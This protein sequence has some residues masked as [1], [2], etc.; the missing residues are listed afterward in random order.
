MRSNTQVSK[1]TTFT[2]YLLW[3]RD[4]KK[5]V[6][7][8]TQYTFS[9]NGKRVKFL[10]NTQKSLPSLNFADEGVLSMQVYESFNI[11]RKTLYSSIQTSKKII[12]FH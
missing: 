10:Y 3:E 6:Y 9:E 8:E 12:F 2:I 4:S 7:G 1:N 11:E 5:E